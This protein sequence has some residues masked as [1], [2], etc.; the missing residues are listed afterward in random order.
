M[1]FIQRTG[2][3]SCF[4]QQW[5][6]TDFTEADRW[7]N[8][9]QSWLNTDYATN[10]KSFAGNGY[11]WAI[12]SDAQSTQAV[13]MYI[14]TSISGDRHFAGAS[15]ASVNSFRANSDLTTMQY[16]ND[17]SFGYLD[18]YYGANLDF[19]DKSRVCIIRLEA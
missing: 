10:G 14:T 3:G 6:T 11:I 17:T 16:G 2:T 12:F 18:S 8:Q 9:S 5:H 15:I 13:S 4:A 19:N 1:S 7:S